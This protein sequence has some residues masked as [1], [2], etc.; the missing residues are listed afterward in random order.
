MVHLKRFIKVNKINPL[1]KYES[2]SEGNLNALTEMT[3]ELWPECHFE[4]EKSNWK[5]LIGKPIHFVELAK[6]N[7]VY[8]G[9]IHVS[10]RYEFVEG[11]DFEA[12]AY[13]EG[14]Y[15][16]PAY[17]KVRAANQMLTH[18]EKWSRMQGLKQIASDTEIT[19]LVSQNFH[20]NTGFTELN[21][22][23]CFI[24]SL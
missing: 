12:I 9:F 11:S 7:D 15:V 2:I 6:I 24:K 14:I 13:L 23:V 3:I 20:K 5:Q 16:K 21:R 19:N 4:E 10:V 8:I 18:A 22:I 1:F 17:R